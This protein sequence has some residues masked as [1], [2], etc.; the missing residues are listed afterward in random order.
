MKTLL[1]ITLL[2]F[3]LPV[4]AQWGAPASAITIHVLADGTR[5]FVFVYPPKGGVYKGMT[6]DQAEEW[7]MMELARNLAEKHWCLHGW[8]IDSKTTQMKNL[9]Y[10]G[11]CN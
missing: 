7:R 11:T 3:S 6:P 2:A 10:K 1:L 5:G 9:V 8:A 4:F